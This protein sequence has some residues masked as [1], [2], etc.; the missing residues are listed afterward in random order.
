MTFDAMQ[1]PDKSLDGELSILE[2]MH[3]QKLY[4]ASMDI[5]DPELEAQFA[6][7]KDLLY[8]YNLTRP[9]ELDRRTEILS[10]V[11]ASM[12]KNCYI[13]PPFYANWGCHTSVG[14]NFYANFG[15]TLVDDTYITI[16]NSVMIAPHVTLATGTHPI[17]P[18]LRDQMLQYNLPIVIEDSVWIGAGAIVLPGVTI[19]KGSVIGAGS[20]V[21]KSVPTGVVAVGNPCRVLREIGERDRRFYYKDRPIEIV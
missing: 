6:A 2:K 1:N 21:T 10:Q 3:S 4:D 19:G 16:G 15:L 14:D 17:D 5:F 12:G 20:V 13:E 11:L 7:L 18:A 8:T 9:S